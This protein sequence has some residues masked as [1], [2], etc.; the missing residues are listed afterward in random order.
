MGITVR[1][2]S[3]AAAMAAGQI[4]SERVVNKL[5][6]FRPIELTLEYPLEPT[7]DP[8]V[9]NDLVQYKAYFDKQFPRL[10]EIIG[11]KW[12]GQPP[13]GGAGGM[14]GGYGGMPGG[15]GMEAGYT[16]GPRAAV[17]I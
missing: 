8:L 4:L 13:V 11:C 17:A 12:V 16:A 10:A 14:G 2:T 15:G 1:A 7:K 9:R 3:A 6:K 5:K